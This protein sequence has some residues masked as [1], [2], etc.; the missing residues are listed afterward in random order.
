M[1]KKKNSIINIGD[2]KSINFN[3]IIDFSKDIIDGKINSFNKEKKYNEK[4][5]DIEK[6]LENKKKT[7]N[8]IKLYIF[9]LNQLKGILFTHKKA[10]GMPTK[11]PQII[12]KRDDKVRTFDL[13][14]FK[15]DSLPKYNE[16]SNRLKNLEEEYQNI[17]EEKN[18]PNPKYIEKIMKNSEFY[19]YEL[20]ISDS[21]IKYFDK[22]IKENQKCQIKN[23]YNKSIENVI[24]N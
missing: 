21:R 19:K 23:R 11:I 1:L 20:D 9:Y 22:I 13:K 16:K 14:D 5:K 24:Y 8:D 4:F 18:I 15:K 3:D 10:S 12:R 2:N 6:N 7:T 17:M